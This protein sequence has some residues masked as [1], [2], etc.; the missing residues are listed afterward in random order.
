MDKPL[1][2]VI[3]AAKN[4]EA[5]LG[6]CLTSVQTLDYLAYEVIVVDDGSSD[7][8]CEI[9]KNFPQVKVLRAEGVG[10]SG[11]RNMAVKEAKGEFVAF[12]D[13]DCIV[14]K[15]WL[16]ELMKGFASQEIVSVGG[17]QRSPAD[18]TFFGRKVHQFLGKCGFFTNY[19]QSAQGI[20]EVAHSPSCNVIYRKEVYEK[21][22]GFLAG[23]WPGEDL[24][25]DYRLVQKGYKLVN[26][27]AAV[28]SHYRTR[29]LD[30]FW[31]MMF[32][33]G[34]AQGQLVKMHGIFRALQGLPFLT[35]FGMI[36]LAVGFA[37]HSVLTMIAVFFCAGAI[38]GWLSFDPV[39]FGLGIIA[40]LAWHVGFIKAVFSK[41]AKLYS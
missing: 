19:M 1:I 10:P 4:A 30:G 35:M 26:N 15:A 29:S 17:S 40:F 25:L 13:A 7:K 37:T 33:Y 22:G 14:D 18:E 38:F 20:R 23:F 21:F 5:T 27:P 41:Q 3:I 39:L 36:L 9:A 34:W 12:T 24:E 16:N 11:A 6:K 32:R 2:S 31:R 28:V 8:T